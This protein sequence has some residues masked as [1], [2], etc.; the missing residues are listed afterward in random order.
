M[1]YQ[2]LII[3]V[4]IIVVLIVFWLLLKKAFKMSLVL[5]L[6][7]LLFNVAFVFSG[8]DIE[9]SFFTRY[10]DREKSDMLVD[11]FNDF[12]DRREELAIVD[13][14][15]MSEDVKERLEQGYYFVIEGMGAVNVED[16]IDDLRD[17]LVGAQVDLKEL[18]K[19]RLAS[20]VEDKLGI[21]YDDAEYIASQVLKKE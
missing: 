18:D 2:L 8:Q 6:I 9:N 19:E 12:S 13:T 11:F 3:P 1:D 21:S 20:L 15:K 16:F 5:V 10:L 7:F 17:S 14:N 4:G